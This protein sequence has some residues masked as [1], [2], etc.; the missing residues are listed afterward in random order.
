MPA[1]SSRNPEFAGKIPNFINPPSGG[2]RRS[3]ADLAGFRS[4][5]PGKGVFVHRREAA[6]GLAFADTKFQA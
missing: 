3:R 4:W 6:T 1:A 2:N 5:S